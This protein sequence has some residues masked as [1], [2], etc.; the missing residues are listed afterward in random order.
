MKL[1]FFASD[2]SI[3]LSSILCEQLIAY[4]NIDKWSVIGV[5]GER[6]QEPSLDNQLLENHISLIRIPGLDDH[7]N[8][9]WL[10]KELASFISSE[11]PEIIHVQNNWQLVL[12]GLIKYLRFSHVKFKVVYTIH[13]FRN[14]HP[15]KSIIAPFIIGSLLFI[16]ADRV[17]YLSDYVRRKFLFISYKMTLL[18]YGMNHGFFNKETN[19]IDCSHFKL[20]FSAQFRL[21]KNQDMLIRAFIRYCNE[22]KD[23]FSTLYLPGDGEFRNKCQDLASKSEY[24]NQIIFPG[25]LAK[26][27]IVDLM[28]QC[29]IAVITSSSETFGQAIVEPYVLGMCILTTKVGVA[30]DIIRDGVNGFFFKNEE[31]LTM[32]L[33]KISK[34][35][36]LI[37]KI[38]NNNFLNRERFSWKNSAIE[39]ARLI[40]QL[41]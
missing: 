3:G 22:T 2:Y 17:I 26:K 34:D 12:L 29:N 39:Y 9:L 6:S 27:D 1:L 20:I 32:L 25:L 36:Q 19:T 16:F 37:Q 35:K 14:Y 18:H 11:K 31:E 30:P 33:M 41:V 21:G 7:R 8:F 10:L 4:Q 23:I 28:L 40:N 24:S 13:G 15:V 38:G 5:A